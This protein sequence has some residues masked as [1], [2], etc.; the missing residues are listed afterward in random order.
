ML[1]VLRTGTR[2]QGLYLLCNDTDTIYV[3]VNDTIVFK[4]DILKGTRASNK[5]FTYMQ[6][7][8]LL[9]YTF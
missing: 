4:N 5:H 9:D 7:N 1:F 8:E 2:Q 3:P 6:T